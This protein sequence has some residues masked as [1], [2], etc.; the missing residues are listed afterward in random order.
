MRN[1]G[2]YDP[3]TISQYGELARLRSDQGDLAGANQIYEQALASF[4][5]LAKPDTRYVAMLE[6]Y[7]DTLAHAKRQKEAD[8]IYDEARAFYQKKDR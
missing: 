3:D 7:G 1:L 6:V 2:P 8:K 5:K 4:R